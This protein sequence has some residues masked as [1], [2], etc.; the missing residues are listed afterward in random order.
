MG[1]DL[2]AFRGRSTGRLQGVRGHNGEGGLHV[3]AGR[4]FGTLAST[5]A[6]KTGVV[7]HRAKS[8]RHPRGHDELRRVSNSEKRKRIKSLEEGKLI[9]YFYLRPKHNS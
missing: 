7:P 2:R 3:A 8:E 1:I 4:E 6:R 9:V 5:G